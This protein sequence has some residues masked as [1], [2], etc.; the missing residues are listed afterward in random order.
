MR[1]HDDGADHDGVALAAAAAQGGGAGAAAAAGELEGEVQGDAVAG[2][3]EGVADGDGSAVD[4][5]D[6]HRD[7]EVVGG[8]DADRGERFVDLEQVDVGRRSCRR[9]R[10][11]P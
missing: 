10:G 6:V 5:D 2:H 11:R 7:A 9:G 8:R 3:A 4:V 1:H